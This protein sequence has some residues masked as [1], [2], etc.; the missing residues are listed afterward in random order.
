MVNNVTIMQ[1]GKLCKLELQSF[2]NEEFVEI[3]SIRSMR[4]Y[5]PNI[6]AQTKLALIGRLTRR[7]LFQVHKYLR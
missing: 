5:V 3:K 1:E 4:I 2:L 6:E 7:C